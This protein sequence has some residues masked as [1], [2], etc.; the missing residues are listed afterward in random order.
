MDI[1]ASLRKLKKGNNLIENKES[2][3]VTKS[4]MKISKEEASHYCSME[5]SREDFRNSS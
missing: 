1:A 3:S 4:I 2:G 5:Y